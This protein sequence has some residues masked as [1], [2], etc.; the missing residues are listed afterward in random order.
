MYPVVFFDALRVKIREDALVRNKAVYLA[1]GMLPDGTRDVL[2]IWI[3]QT[4]GA[5]FWLKVFN[6]LKTRGV[7]DILIAVVDGLK[8]L[9]E[10]ITVAFPR[11][12]V[13][14]CIVHLIRNSLEYVSWKDR[15]AVAAA[16]KPI[17]AAASAEAAEEALAAFAA[18]PW[19]QK[20]P[21]IAPIWRRA[22]EHVIPF[23]A[24]P[25]AIRRVLYTTNAIESLHMQLRKIIKTRGH[26]PSDEAA[27][28][29]LWL[30]L[31]KVLAKR[32]RPTYDWRPV[33]SQFAVLFGTRFT[34]SEA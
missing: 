20:H 12:T 10:A 1:L 24:F 34:R 28:K 8:G 29:L 21:T 19:G 14:T 2:G 31:R 6:E 7:D 18:G 17:Y 4:E 11:T 27:I 30:A 22:W 13:Q 9:A 3:E 25:P 23:F 26:F 32:V 15:K 16:L 33:M 5:K